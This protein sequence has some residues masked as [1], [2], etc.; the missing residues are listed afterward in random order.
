MDSQD[1]S[2]GQRVRFC[3]FSEPGEFVC[4]KQSARSE[5]NA[6]KGRFSIESLLGSESSEHGYL[7]C[8]KRVFAC[9]SRA[10]SDLLTAVRESVNTFR[11]LSLER[12][13][14]EARIQ[15]QSIQI[16]LSIFAS[17]SNSIQTLN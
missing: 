12:K 5:Q 15:T 14:I 1:R 13:P 6:Q 11:V 8:T 9:S 17:S 4:E 7:S 16:A 10:N 2:L 3:N